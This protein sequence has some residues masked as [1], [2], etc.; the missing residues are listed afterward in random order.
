MADYDV[1]ARRL[2]SPP[3]TA[4]LTPY[5]PGVEMEN[6]GI[7]SRIAFGTLS[8]Y[9]KTT[10]LLVKTVS[11]QSSL[12]PPG[13]KRTA[14]STEYWTP[15]EVGTYFAIATVSCDLD[16][17]ESNNHLSPTTFVVTDEPPPPPPEVPAH[18][19]QH[20]DGGSDELTL[21]SMSGLLHDPQTPILH[22]ATHAVNG[23]DVLAVDGLS[24]QLADGQ[25]PLEH[26]ASHE[27]NGDD[28][29]SVAGLSGELSDDQPPKEHTS[30][31]HD[32]SVEATANKGTVSGYAPLD[33]D[34]KLPLANLT[35]GVEMQANKGAV[36]GYAPLDANTKLPLT[37]LTAG[38]EM[39][40]NKGTM[41]GYAPLDADI[42]VPL[43]NAPQISRIRVH[44]TD[45]PSNPTVV[46][47]GEAREL[48]LINISPVQEAGQF[49]LKTI[50]QIDAPA[51][52]A[53]GLIHLRINDDEAE[54]PFVLPPG[55]ITLCLPASSTGGVTPGESAQCI[56]T[57]VCLTGGPITAT[58]LW[59]EIIGTLL[60]VP[61]PPP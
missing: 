30:A 2:T 36:S 39:Q 55:P 26:K 50:V 33:A 43:A 57:V 56:I 49:I 4:Y 41:S 22:Q 53:R 44:A 5:R 51:A 60:Q 8:I 18:A 14:E 29:I 21:E 11:V 3:A 6:L 15:P 16:Q 23:D 58:V 32:S 42:R 59:E 13:D 17:V 48:S 1:A 46:P 10:G 7:H 38:V 19:T 24:G 27:F 45:V 28:K 31:K 35:A 37:N 12:I 9:N 52:G 25:T 61:P 54:F 34:T 40:A 47:T 20:E